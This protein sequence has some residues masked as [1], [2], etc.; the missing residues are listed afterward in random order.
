[1]GYLDDYIGGKKTVLI[2]LVGLSFAVLTIVL[3]RNLTLFW[4]AAGVIAIR[5]GPNQAA[6]RSLLARFVREDRENEFF[7]FF[8]FS[9]KFTA[10]LG[11]LLLAQMILAFG[12]QRAGIA[13]VIVLFV[14]G[15]LILTTVNEKEGIDASGRATYGDQPG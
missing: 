7:G 8:A 2:N 15:G 3:T 11:P 10:F 14:V 1:M 9:G 4:V 5:A 12:N 6:S 13:V